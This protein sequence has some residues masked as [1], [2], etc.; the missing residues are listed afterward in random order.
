MEALTKTFSKL[1]FSKFDNDSPASIAVAVA[2]VGVSALLVKKL[3]SPGYKKQKQVILITGAS[4]GIGKKTALAFLEKGHVV[5]G[6]ARRVDKM[7]DL[8]AAGMFLMCVM[9]C[10]RRICIPHTSCLQNRGSRTR[11]RCRR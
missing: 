10:T 4:S 5:Y 2:A 7:Q 9:R 8:V 3:L 11:S 1:D 6:A